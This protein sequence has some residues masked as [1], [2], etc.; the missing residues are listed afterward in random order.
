MASSHT[1]SREET[2]AY[3]EHINSVLGHDKDIKSLFPI[4][5]EGRDLFEK[6]ADGRLLCK[7]INNAVPDTI[8]ERVVNL[9]DKL[10]QYQAAEN[11]NLAIN[12]AKA[13]GCSIVNIGAGDIWEQREHLILGVV[14][15]VIRIGL[16][17]DISLTSHPELY[18]LLEEGEDLKDFLKL[19]PEKILLRWVNYHLKNAGS[20]R[21]INNFGKDI[22]DS[23]VYTLL[24]NQLS[25]LCDKSP[26]NEKDLEK[27]ADGVLKNAGKIDCAKFVKSRDIVAGNPKLNLAFVAN[28]FNTLPGLEPLK[29]EEMK[30]LEF[31][32]GGSREARAFT[33]W[34]NSLGIDPFVN[35]LFEDLKNGLILLKIE[36]KL[37]PGCVDWKRVNQRE[38]MHRIKCVE[39]TNYAVDIGKDT[40]KFSLVNVSGVDITDGS[41][42][43]T[44]ALVWQLMRQHVLTVL[45]EVGGGAPVSEDAMIKWSNDLVKS[46]GKHSKM[47]NFKDTSLKNSQF[48]LD[49][50]DAIRPGC[51]DPSLILNS[52]SEED[53]LK[54]AKYAISMARKLGATIFLLPEDIVEVKP[55]MIL[56]FIGS[57]M[58][59]GKKE[60]K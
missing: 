14:W 50:L 10:N 3:V 23:E 1:Y 12:S 25:P 44:L 48:F 31:P 18:R 22:S 9:K 35:N 19:P 7:L 8:D 42:T 54:N 17:S 37:Q 45:K 26:L 29:E 38:P 32:E 51:V 30:N 60:G 56:T 57:L 27:R 49:L 6:C 13:I 4:K 16:M 46:S 47:D 41:E 36:D 39:N 40:L 34:I 33:L 21:R 59:V 58:A 5:P 28:L 11:H 52:G 55:K 53:A 15:Q 24:L 2:E 43:L 20:D